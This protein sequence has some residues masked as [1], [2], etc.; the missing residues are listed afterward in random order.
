MNEDFIYNI[1][2]TMCIDMLCTWIVETLCYPTVS[3]R[4]IR[5]PAGGC[6]C[7]TSTDS[8]NSRRTTKSL[9]SMDSLL[10]FKTS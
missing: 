2:F 4:A 5:L 1:I 7:T 3:Y 10:R 9:L 8:E 6:A